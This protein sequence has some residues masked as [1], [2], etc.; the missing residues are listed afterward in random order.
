MSKSKKLR[1][2]EYVPAAMTLMKSFVRDRDELSRRFT[3]LTEDYENDFAGQIMMV[4][5]LE[6]SLVLT[7]EQKEATDAL[8]KASD[9]ISKELSFLTFHFKRA[10]LYPGILTMVKKELAKRN[11]E[12]ACQK[13]GGLISY[14]SAEHEILESKGMEV[15][16]PSEL[17]M[18]KADLEMKNSFLNELID[19]KDQ[20][21]EDNIEEYKALYSFIT[22]VSNAGKVIYEGLDKEDEYILS[23]I[24]GQ[25]RSVK[26]NED[27]FSH[28]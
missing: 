20:L 3:E 9:A 10:A 2:E 13:I 8:Y 17:I 22:T 15:G 26:N 16:F 12:G 21:Y 27:V 7:E 11:I 19:N 1:V 6:Q 25:M 5:K 24:I 18:M 28:I 14:V 4:S 23:K